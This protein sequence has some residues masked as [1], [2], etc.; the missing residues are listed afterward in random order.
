MITRSTIFALAL[1]LG[2]APALAAP[3][4]DAPT[5]SVRIDDLNL[6]TEQGQQRLDVRIKKAARTVCYSGL[7]GLAAQ[8]REAQ[9][10]D[11]ALAVVQP[12]AARAVAQAQGGTQLALLMVS[13]V[14]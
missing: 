13:A 5:A 14:R 12:E 1:T 3:T 7:R 11:S 6:S 4:S 8:A 9:C 10:I 2:A